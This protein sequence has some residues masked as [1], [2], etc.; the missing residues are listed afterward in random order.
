MM[1]LENIKKKMATWEENN[2]KLEQKVESLEDD[3][4]KLRQKLKNQEPLSDSQDSN[5]NSPP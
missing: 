2:K 4:K 3:N 5:S 1:D